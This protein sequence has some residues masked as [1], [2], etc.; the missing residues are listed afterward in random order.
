MP[1]QVHAALDARLPLVLVHESRGEEHGQ[2]PFEHFFDVAPSELR[3][4][5]ICTP[6]TILTYP[7]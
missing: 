4:K 5:G 7:L 1:T 6:S 3:L 2:R